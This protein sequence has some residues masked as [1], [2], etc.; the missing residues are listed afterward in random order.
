[1]NAFSRVSGDIF[2]F[3]CPSGSRS[4][5]VQHQGLQ[6]SCATLI[7]CPDGAWARDKGAGWSSPGPW[8]LASVSEG[9][10]WWQVPRKT[11]KTQPIHGLASA[12]G[13]RWQVL[14]EA[15]G[16]LCV[17]GLA[18]AVPAAA[19]LTL[20]PT[21]GSLQLLGVWGFF[22]V[23]SCLFSDLLV[24]LVSPGGRFAWFPGRDSGF[25]SLF[26]NPGGVGLP[27]T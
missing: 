8:G 5:Q 17:A 16:A 11:A 7:V 24:G 26:L 3:A 27:L 4:G 25:V 20:T 14:S 19:R 2:L 23:P 21:S 18:V 13:Q 12:R 1:M 15:C 10:P 6:M 22:W 9:Q